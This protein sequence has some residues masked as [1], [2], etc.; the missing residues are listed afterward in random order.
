MGRIYLR[1]IVIFRFNPQHV[2]PCFSGPV[3]CPVPTALLWVSSRSH[4]KIRAPSDGSS[5]EAQLIAVS[6]SD[7]WTLHRVLTLP[8]KQ[9]E[10]GETDTERAEVLIGWA[11]KT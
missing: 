8:I 3:F 7:L 4:V 1:H 6:I 2:V 5:G 10:K 9:R 11:P